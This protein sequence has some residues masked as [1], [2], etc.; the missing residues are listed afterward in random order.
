[1][2]KL[3]FKEISLKNAK[4]IIREKNSDVRGYLSR[5]FC[6]DEIN[7]D[8]EFDS[9]KQI[10]IS[11]TKSKHTLRGLHFQK[12]PFA[13]KKI[14][15]CIKGKIFDI[16]VDLRKNSPTFLKFHNEILSENNQTSLLVPEGFA[17]GFLSL[18]DDCKVLYFHSK[19]YNPN[20]ESGIK[21]DDPKIGINWPSEPKE[22]SERDL[23]F[24]LIDEKFRGIDL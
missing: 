4:V 19:N 18:E 16:I 22:I 1:M 14:V 8:S 17:H 12:S 15:T 9:L 6:L 10:N 24:P 11:Y 2:K 3:E 21:Y 20:Y 23:S 7:E 5:L 13:E